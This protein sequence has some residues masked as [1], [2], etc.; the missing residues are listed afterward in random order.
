MKIRRI[1]IGAVLVIIG[2][3]VVLILIAIVSISILDRTNGTIVTSG[4]NREYLLYVPPSYGGACCRSK[5]CPG[6]F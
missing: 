4:Q 3:P 6:T 1:L 2:L 5:D